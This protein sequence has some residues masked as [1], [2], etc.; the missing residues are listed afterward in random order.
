MHRL[1]CL[2]LALATTAADAA[3]GQPEADDPR[4]PLSADDIARQVYCA[5]RGLRLKQ[6]VTRETDGEIA[7]LVNAMPGERP[8]VSSLE[9]YLN[10]E[11]DDGETGFKQLVIFRSGHLRGTGILM[12]SPADRRSAPRIAMWLPTVRK[13]RRIAA[14]DPADQWMGSTLT[15]GDVLLRK[16]EDEHHELVGIERFE[17]CLGVLEVP[18]EHRTK[19]I[20]SLP[21]AQCG[22]EG[23]P[24]YKIR[25]SSKRDDW[26]YDHRIS[27]VDT[28]SFALYRTVFFKNQVAV[29]RI[30]MDWRGL[31]ASDPRIVYP[32]YVY[33]K[34][35]ANGAQSML[36][37]PA[38]TV[39]IDTRLPDSFWSEG[40]LRRIKR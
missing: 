28:T 30:E 6:A 25:S 8:A 31:D 27:W 10:T 4:S 15:Y 12:T 23:K 36:Y 37:L 13:V 22:H 18:E 14:P 39:A 20:R 33:S 24:V 17:G 21:G 29:K 3:L 1:L 38:A 26:W 5:A 32:S 7:L 40:T 11:V 34:S 35:I 19:H 16:P 2:L 9:A